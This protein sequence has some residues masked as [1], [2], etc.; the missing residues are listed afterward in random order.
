MPRTTNKEI[1]RM[2]TILLSVGADV[3]VNTNAGGY[4][5]ESGDGTRD[6]GPRLQTRREFLT[7]LDGFYNGWLERMSKRRGR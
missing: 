4:R 5:L 7:F 6:I 2:I 1:D 3:A